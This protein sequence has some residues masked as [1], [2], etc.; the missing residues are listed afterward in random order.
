M[1][2]GSPQ[3][4]ASGWCRWVA[5]LQVLVS[6]LLELAIVTVGFNLILRRSFAAL[7]HP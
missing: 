5:I 3:Y 4:E 2:K 1:V 7:S 6:R